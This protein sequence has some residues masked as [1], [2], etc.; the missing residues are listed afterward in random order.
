MDLALLGTGLMGL[1]MGT[2]LLEAG[3]RL[4]VFNRTASK[5]QPLVDA[6]ATAA[7][8]PAEAVAAA[9]VTLV[10]V[11]DAAAV[12][13]VLL[14]SGVDLDG[15]RIVQMSTVGPD[16]NRALH[17]DVTAAGGRFLEAPVLGSTPQAKGGKLVVMGGGTR[18]DFDH[19]REV[20]AVF[21]PE[22]RYVGEVGKAAT[23]KLAC[24][25]LIAAETAAFSLSL[26][27]IRRG[28]VDIDQFVGV[29]HD[30]VL[31][32]PLFD[33]KLQALRERDFRPAAFPAQHLLKDVRLG[34]DLAEQLDL[35][36][37]GLTLLRTIL[38]ETVDAGHAEDDFSA[39]IQRVDPL[40]DDADES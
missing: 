36:P 30:S 25:H 40:D 19:V 13:S 33:F 38:E 7:A 24:N 18:E 9:E 3:H 17:A 15:K 1:P 20:L 12:R 37:R 26:G 5:A 32:A 10:M 29:L 22:P 39:L 16:E 31:H 8:T 35:D 2:R 6:G 23:M 28:G 4:T 14:E 21:G 11:S 27:L 34:H